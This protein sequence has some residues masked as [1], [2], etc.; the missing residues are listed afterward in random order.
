MTGKRVGLSIQSHIRIDDK[1]QIGSRNYRLLDKLS[2]YDYIK[3]FKRER[4]KR[5]GSTTQWLTK[6]PTFDKW[7]RGAEASL[8]W[9]SG[10]SEP[11]QELFFNLFVI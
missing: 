8:L 5:Y 3:P 4:M 9:C 11:R 7:V 10:K 1:L 2:K 6:H